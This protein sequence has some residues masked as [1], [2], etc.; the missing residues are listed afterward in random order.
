MIGAYPGYKGALKPSGKV[1]VHFLHGD[2]FRFSLSLKGLETNCIKCGIHIHSGTTCSDAA[3]VGGHYWNPAVYG[4]NVT[5]DPW[6]P[7][8]G[9]YYTSDASGKALRYFYTD[10]GYGYDDT[11]NHAVVIHANDGSRIGCA[12]LG[13]KW[14]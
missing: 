3:L 10:Q 5:G 1:N 13:P 11:I 2:L 4:V 7:S 12:T 8:K 6:V 9:A 14:W